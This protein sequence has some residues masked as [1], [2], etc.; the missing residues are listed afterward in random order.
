MLIRTHRIRRI[1]KNGIIQIPK[2]IRNAYKIEEG[3]PME[4]FITEIDGKPA[5]C[6]QH[7]T[8]KGKREE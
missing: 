1:E 3:T 2:Q 4:I 6:F 8:A 7:Y 5:V